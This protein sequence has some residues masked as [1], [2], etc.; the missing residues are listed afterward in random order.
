MNDSGLDATNESRVLSALKGKQI[1]ITG[2]SGFLGKVLLEKLIHT[3]P[4]IGGIHLLIRAN[5]KHRSARDRFVNEIAS[6]SVFE[7]LKLRD[8]DA[9]EQFL[10]DKVHCVTGEITEPFFGQSKK[11]FQALASKID[12]VINSAASVNFREELDKAL[13]INTLCL[14]NLIEFARDAGDIPVLQVSTCYVNGFNKGNMHEDVVRPHSGRL[15]RHADGYYEV[16]DLIT[17]LLDKVADVKARYSGDQLKDKLIELG[18]R[19]AHHYGWNDTYTFTKWMGEQLL[20]KALRGSTLTILRPSIIESTLQSP[21]PGWIE[22]VKVADA[23]I[24]AYAKQK[25]LV[26]PGRR[27][28]TIDV[29]PADLVANSIIMAVAEQILEPSRQRIYQCCSGSRNPLLVGEFIDHVMAEAKENFAAYERLFPSQPTKPFIALDRRV[30]NAVSTGVRRPLKMLDKGLKRLGQ[31]YDL[32]VMGS[33]ETTLK[34]AEVFSFYSSPEYVFHSD[35]LLSL[36]QRMTETDRRLFPVDSGLVNW[37]HYI[38]KIHLAGLNRYAL[39]ERKLYR[40][41][42]GKRRVA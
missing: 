3:I 42:T 39:K 41:K 13:T 12:V 2:T 8:H 26:F 33:L 9:F 1:L 24:L 19:E 6:S 4:D 32:K 20:L 40:L 25:V 37:E 5:E 22:G 38:R 30:F 18:I 15:V 34:L 29:I 23:V 28:G 21:S 16:E 7:Q 27:G 11:Q 10:E 36:S 17:V 31:G 14:R 35:K